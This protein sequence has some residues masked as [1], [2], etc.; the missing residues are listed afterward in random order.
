MHTPLNIG[1]TLRAPR[2][3]A[4]PGATV[5]VGDLASESIRPPDDTDLGMPDGSSSRRQPERQTT[6]EKYAEDG[7][8]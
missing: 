5:S 6:S 1:G 4:N 2:I 3:P 8:R 7:L